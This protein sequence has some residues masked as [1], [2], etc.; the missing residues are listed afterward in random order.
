ME[1]AASGAL[2]FVLRGEAI[3]DETRALLA[4]LAT[5]ADAIWR[6]WSSP[7]ICD[8]S[9]NL[10]MELVAKLAD[11]KISDRACGLLE[12]DPPASD[13][14]DMI[15]HYIDNVL[16]DNQLERVLDHLIRDIEYDLAG[17]QLVR[18]A[19][20][21]LRTRDAMSEEQAYLYLRYT[22]RSSRRRIADVAA[23][24]VKQGA[25]K[26]AAIKHTEVQPLRRG[27]AS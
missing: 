8:R 15:S 20:A 24:I 7:R 13:A 9:L 5:A 6:H 11:S 23:E 22:S 16:R 27:V 10:I 1:N 14:V 12:S 26:P 4:Q 3:S 2:S 19:K 17:Y 21:I 25:T 18:K